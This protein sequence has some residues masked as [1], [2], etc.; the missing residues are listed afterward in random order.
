M[1]ASTPI[2]AGSLPWG[3]MMWSLWTTTPLVPP[4][5]LGDPHERGVFVEVAAPDEVRITASAWL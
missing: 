1:S 2:L 4:P 3:L 5:A